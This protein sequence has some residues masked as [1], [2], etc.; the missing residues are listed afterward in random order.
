VDLVLAAR[1]PFSRLR[2]EWADTPGTEPAVDEPVTVITDPAAVRT[3]AD[4]VLLATKT[5]QTAGAAPWLDAL[6]GRHTVVAV[7]QNGIGHHGLVDPLVGPATVV[8]TIVFLPAD[9]R[10]PGHVRAGRPIALRVP[11]DRGGRRVVDLFAG[12]WV[13]VHGDAD[14]HT[15]AWS[16][17]VSNCAVGAVTTLT[18]TSNRVLEDPEARAVAEA[19]LHETVAV[20]IADGAALPEALADGIVDIVLDRAAD[21]VSSQ[22]TDR[23]AGVATEWE[24]RQLEVVRRADRHGV[25]V[26]T[27]RLLTTLIRLGEPDAVS[28]PTGPA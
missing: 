21:H 4:I 13:D 25:E 3:P 8:P 7:L 14:F 16:K 11:E 9:R 27:L 18:R 28:R 24:A 17:L 10:G 1:T 23:L 15:T 20:A 6:C 12:T 2:V 19:V 5:H 22:T 26:P